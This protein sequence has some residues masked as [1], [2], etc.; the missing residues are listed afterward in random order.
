MQL[1][2]FLE[3]YCISVLACPGYL[4]VVWWAF[5]YPYA[6]T[7]IVVS[8]VM[9]LEANHRNQ[10]FCNLQGV[11]FII[12]WCKYTKA[13][14]RNYLTICSPKVLSLQCLCLLPSREGV[15]YPIP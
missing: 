6:K 10:T 2:N 4:Y 8:R 13:I 11:G 14:G 5:V 12:H 1:F 7:L 15:F 9:D 3:V